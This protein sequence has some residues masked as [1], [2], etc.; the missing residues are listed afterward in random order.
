MHARVLVCLGNFKG[1]NIFQC[2]SANTSISS[3]FTPPPEREPVNK[4]LLLVLE[5]LHLSLCGLNRDP[6]PL[7]NETDRRLIASRRRSPSTQFTRG[8]AHRERTSQ[9][10]LSL[11][12]EKYCILLSQASSENPKRPCDT[13]GGRLPPGE[14]PTPPRGSRAASLSPPQRFTHPIASPQRESDH[15]S[16]SPQKL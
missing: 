8:L 7:C 15:L 10:G 9:K 1:R 2:F 4:G 13:P 14:R 3:Y 16:S 11:L 12:L 6:A 5:R